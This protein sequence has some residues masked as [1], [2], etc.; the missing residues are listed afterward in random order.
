MN[1]SISFPDRH[2][3]LPVGLRLAQQFTHLHH[4]AEQKKQDALEEADDVTD[5][6]TLDVVSQEDVDEN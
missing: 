4:V 3:D 5:E 2:S 6:D 1:L